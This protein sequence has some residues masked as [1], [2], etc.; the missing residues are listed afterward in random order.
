LTLKG[1]CAS[2]SEYPDFMKR[3]LGDWKLAGGFSALLFL[4]VA[5]GGIG[6]F[7]IQF[8]SKSI[9]DLGK[10]YFPLQKAALEMRIDNSLY[11]TGIRNYIFWRSARYLEAA[12]DAA[13]Q[14]AINT[15][16]I[17]F[18]G[19]L[20]G[21]TS[22][23]RTARQRQWIK[24]VRVL[25]QELYGVGEKIVDEADRLENTG[26]IQRRKIED[27][28]DKLVMVFENKLHKIDEFIDGNIQKA[29]LEAVEEKLYLAELAK[30]RAIKLLIW[31][32]IL[33]LGLGG[34]TAWLI[35]RN[36]K[37]EQERRKKLVQRMIRAEELERQN[38]SFQVHDQMGQDLS[39]LM[40]YTDL[41]DKKLDPSNK[42]AK[43]DILQ[44]KKILS[45]LIDK[46]HNIA[47]L[48]RPPALEEIGLVDTIAG[49]IFQYKHITSI[50]FS[51]NLPAEPLNLPGEYSL[52]LYRVAQEGLTNIVKHSQAKKVEISLEKKAN[53]IYLTV[54]DDGIGFNYK[55][56]L[57]LRR[58]QDKLRLGLL[59][60]R[61]RIELLGGKMTVN[62]AP[63]RGTKLIV[64]LPIKEKGDASIF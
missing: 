61:E 22:F 27:A 62:T 47:E 34:E 8:L 39:A 59:G 14:E 3:Y 32:L 55:Q 16:R 24:R 12:K 58:K 9:D 53:A 48:L 42:E 11:A 44:S 28:I 7:Q 50:E 33:G 64:N 31:S 1:P 5:I 60:L 21:Y 52:I 10:Y 26:G 30:K 15:A 23:A 36:H 25:E 2:E 17:G 49:L 45:D 13:N 51:S 38:L 20:A 63:G 29:N 43:E 18:Q 40:I 46:S 37:S 19:Q 6:I 56:P 41:I 54:A 4:M 57:L 35:Y